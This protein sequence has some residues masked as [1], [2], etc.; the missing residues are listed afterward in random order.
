M[1]RVTVMRLMRKKYGIPAN[2][3]ASAVGVSQQYV[4]DLELGKYLGRYDYTKSGAPLMQKAF[5]R[6]AAARAAQAGR[7]SE[8]LSA[9][10]LCLLDFVEDNYEL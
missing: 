2:E 6:V 9:N 1:S 3:L 10:R 4:N 8:D 7:L 5:G